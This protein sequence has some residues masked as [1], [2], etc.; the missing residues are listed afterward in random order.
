MRCVAYVRRIETRRDVTLQLLR[1]V[2]G[3]DIPIPEEKGFPAVCRRV[4]ANL[5]PPADAHF[6]SV[7]SC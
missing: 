4:D 2:T 3:L 1:C 5:T 6:S 7:I